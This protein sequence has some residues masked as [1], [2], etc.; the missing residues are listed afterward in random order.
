[1]SKI[2]KLNK[3]H[4]NVKKPNSKWLAKRNGIHIDGV[5]TTKQGDYDV[6]CSKYGDQL[7]DLGRQ[8]P[9]V[10]FTYYGT[11]TNLNT[12]ILV[13]NL[14]FMSFGEFDMVLDIPLEELNEEVS[15][16]FNTWTKR[17]Y[18]NK[19]LVNRAYHEAQLNLLEEIEKSIQYVHE[20][21]LEE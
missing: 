2:I 16:E 20:N 3:Q 18:D 19:K 6:I 12:A 15:E 10:G 11:F 1:M 21:E 8:L 14:H 7:N 9:S 13:R 4:K 5:Y 17:S